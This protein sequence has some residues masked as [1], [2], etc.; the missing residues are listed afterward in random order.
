MPRWSSVKLI[1]EGVDGDPKRCKNL[2]PHRN[3]RHASKCFGNDRA[4]QLLMR[5]FL[6]EGLL[7]I[8]VV[9]T[10]FAIWWWATSWGRP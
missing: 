9:I 7:I 6:A 5:Q 1:R 4:R 8:A 2:L 10:G 3:R